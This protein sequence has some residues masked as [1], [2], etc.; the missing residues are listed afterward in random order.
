MFPARLEPD[1]EGRLV[2]HF[3]DLPDALTDCA[4]EA[5]AL[6]EAVDCLSEASRPASLM[7]KRSLRQ[8]SCAMGNIWWRPMPQWR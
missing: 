8:V 5:E 2:V 3:P 4:D 6:A 7:M 1:E